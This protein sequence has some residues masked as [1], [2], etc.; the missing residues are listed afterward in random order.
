MAFTYDL[1]TDRGAVRFSIGDTIEFAGP[2]PT[3]SGGPAQTNF[4]D[5]EI[6]YLLANGGGS[7]A[8]ISGTA[9]G[10]E[11]LASEWTSYALAERDGATG[12][13]MDAKET[14]D[15]FADRA[16][17]WR[18]KPGGGTGSNAL[19]SG[20]IDYNFQQKGDELTDPFP[21]PE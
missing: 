12:N 14:A 20:V 10:L 11:I 16:N 13:T 3:Q 5:D 21:I 17:E 6:D 18:A 1:S 15:T 7:D 19:Q 9:L 8:V 2:R 4:S